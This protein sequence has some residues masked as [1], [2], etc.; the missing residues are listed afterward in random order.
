MCGAVGIQTTLTMFLKAS[1]SNWELGQKMNVAY[2]MII[3][4]QRECGGYTWNKDK[5]SIYV[6]YKLF[7][8]LMVAY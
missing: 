4:I 2:F 5:R 3:M 1:N 8:Y 6:F 7:N